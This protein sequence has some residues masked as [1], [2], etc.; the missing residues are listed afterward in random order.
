MKI[1]TKARYGLRAMIELALH[2]E[3][4][5]PVLMSLVSKNQNLSEKYLHIL[6]TSLKNAKLI[7]SV[8]GKTG[9]FMLSKHPSK[10]NILWIIEALEGPIVLVNC[11]DN[12]GIC[13]RSPKC[14]TINFWKDTGSILKKYFASMTLENFIKKYNGRH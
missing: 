7:K 6:F 1:S 4:K 13:K 3:K 8:R 10:I 2:Y 9:G 5:T 12:K 11:V 14:S